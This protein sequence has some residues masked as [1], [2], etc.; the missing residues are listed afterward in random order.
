MITRIRIDAQ[1]ATAA[2]VESHLHWMAAQIAEALGE[3][4]GTPDP[5][6]KREP[7]I[8]CGEQLIERQVREQQGSFCAHTGRLIVHPNVADDAP[9]VQRLREHYGCSTVMVQLDGSPTPF[10]LSMSGGAPYLD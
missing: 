1:G 10:A 6:T 2:E 9:Q 5:Q 4:A 3:V 7:T 8:S